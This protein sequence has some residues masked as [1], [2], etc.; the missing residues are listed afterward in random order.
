MTRHLF[1]SARLLGT[2]SLMDFEHF[3]Y[4]G[5]VPPK[6]TTR[7][8]SKPP[9][10]RKHSTLNATHKPK[11]SD[12]LCKHCRKQAKQSASKVSVQ[13]QESL[14][15]FFSVSSGAGAASPSSN[16]STGNHEHD[17]PAFKPDEANEASCDQPAFSS[18]VHA[19]ASEAS[20]PA[21]PAAAHGI[22]LCGQCRR[23]MQEK[24]PQLGP[25][26]YSACPFITRLRGYQVLHSEYKYEWVRLP[27]TLPRT[28][29]TFHT[30]T[31]CTY[32]SHFHA[33]HLP[34]LTYCSILSEWR[35]KRACLLS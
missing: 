6:G 21:Q 5:T 1:R 11:D 10:K 19:A 27:F 26:K 29:P 9:H 15:R 34:L 32:L 33:L 2:G 8:A 4:K 17:D 16:A 22:L 35:R 24:A 23:P 14:S 7:T 18:F 28:T 3:R 31:H 30:S 25:R 12:I 13:R 20:E